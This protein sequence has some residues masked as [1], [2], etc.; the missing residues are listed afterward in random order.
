MAGVEHIYIYDLPY[1]ARSEFCKIMNFNEKWEELAGT[2]LR[3]FLTF[4]HYIH[5]LVSLACEF[6]NCGSHN[7]LYE[8]IAKTKKKKPNY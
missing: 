3:K 5:V 7:D 8:I 6:C 1:A 2:S 4:I